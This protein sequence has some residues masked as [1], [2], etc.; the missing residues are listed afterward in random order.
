MTSI[1][2]AADV[3]SG[4]TT[5]PHRRQGVDP[6]TI[7]ITTSNPER[8]PAVRRAGPLHRPEGD[9]WRDPGRRDRQEPYW[10]PERRVRQGRRPGHRP[11]H[12][13]RLHRRPVD[14]SVAQRRLLARASRSSTRSSGGSSRTRTRPS[15]RST[16]A[17]ST[18]PT[19]NRPTTSSARAQQHGRH[20]PAGSVGRDL[21][22]VLNPPKN[23]D[24]ANQEVRQALLYAIDRVSILT[25]IYHIADPQAA[26]LPLPEPDVQP[27]GR[28]QV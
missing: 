11:V 17:R 19:S 25:N 21:D 24:W 15:S 10:T 7:T 16:R 22:L 4:K 1:V 8:A 27:A 14:G 5:G 12:G 18:R 9:R 28:G 2:G 23:P 13:D 6:L 3:I 20:D 26:Q